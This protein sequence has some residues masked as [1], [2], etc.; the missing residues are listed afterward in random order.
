MSQLST[1]ATQLL[2]ELSLQPGIPPY[3]EEAMRLSL[4]QVDD[5]HRQIGEL[6]A[7]ASREAAAAAAAGKRD[8]D[9]DADADADPDADAD[10]DADR[11]PPADA[12]A[13]NADADDQ[14]STAPQQQQPPDW[15][16]HPELAGAVLIHHE[17]IM[18]LKRVLLSYC[19][20]RASRLAS[21]WWR[22]RRLP[23][24]VAGNLSPAERAFFRDYDA[25]MR[26]FMG[27]DDLTL[28]QHPPRD[29]VVACRVLRDHGAV[30]TAA[31]SSVPLLRGSVH[32]LATAEAEPLLRLG[33]LQA[34]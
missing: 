5:H 7:L 19:R 28:D 25:A 12:D 32:L 17:A 2:R 29:A 11:A 31:S 20:V 30:R 3:A 21:Q 16:R 27:L 22:A 23:A 14:P 15:Q 6:L 34:L 4:S 26:R 10:A 33:V 9:A 24:D 18:R 13:A 1:P 8:A